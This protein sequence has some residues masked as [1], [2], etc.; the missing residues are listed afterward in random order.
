MKY[1]LLELKAKSKSFT[2]KHREKRV[3]NVTYK[4]ICYAPKYFLFVIFVLFFAPLRS[5][6][7]ENL[8]VTLSGND[9]SVD[10]IFIIMKQQHNITFSYNNNLLVNKKIHFGKTKLTVVEIV[11]IISAEADVNYKIQVNKVILYPKKK[12]FGITGFIQDSATG[13]KLPGAYIRVKATDYGVEADRDGHYLLKLESGDYVLV[14]SFVG[15]E[16]I[17][18]AITLISE[19]ELSLSLGAATSNIDEVKVTRQRNFWRNLEKG[20][21]M[22]TLDSKKIGTL[23]T[24]NASDILQASIPGVWSTQASGAPGDHQK[25]KIRGINS[26]FGCTDP[27]YIIDGVAVP[28]VNLHSLGIADLNIYD[29]EN[30][31][32]FKDASSNAIYGFQGGNGVIIID[33]K[34]GGEKHISFS[35]KIGIQRIPKR[36]GLMNTKDFLTAM[37]SAVKNNINVNR[38]Y[39]PAYSN[40]LCSTNWQDAVFQDGVLHEYQL[41]GSG[42]IGKNNIYISGNY[43][44]HDGIIDYSS[45][46]RYTASANFGRNF[47]KKLSTELNVRSS[48]QKNTNN[49]DTYNGNNLLIEGINKSPCLKCTP[50]SFYFWPQDPHYMGVRLPINR[51]NFNYQLISSYPES[52]ISTDSIIK[53]N[54]NTLNVLSNAIDLRAKYSF[55]DNLFLNA[56]SSVTLRNNLYQSDIKVDKINSPNFMRSNEHY[57]LFNQQINLNYQKGINNHE[58]LVTSGYRNYADNA[59][60]NLDSIQN[61]NN[62]DNIYLKNSLAI[63]GN[64][65]SVIRQIQSFSALLNYNYSKKYF[66]SL[67]ANYETLTVDKTMDYYALY[68]SIAASWDMSR[69]FLLNR[70]KW[71]D[72][73]SIFANW[74]RVGNMP[75]NALATDFYTNY[76]YNY[77]DTIINGRAVSQFANHY[78]KPEI[79][80]E[81]NLGAKIGLLNKRIRFTADYYFKTSEN[82]IIIRDIPIF[83]GDGRMMLNVGKIV[84]QGKEFSLDIDAVSTANF[85]WS[86][87]F[88]I[89]TNRLQ[90][91]KIGTETQLEFYNSD[92][93]IPQFEVKENEELGVIK[94]YKYLG[95]FI[96]ADKK[97]NDIR[98]TN[99]GGGKYLNSDTAIKSLTAND[100]MVI[101][102]TLPDFTWHWLN[103][104][105]YKNLS[106]EFLWYGVQGV[107]KFNATKAATFM[108]GTNRE[109]MNFMQNKNK[110]LTN[111][112]FYQSSYFVEDA[113][114]VRLKQFTIAYKVPKKIFNL[115]DLKVSVSFENFITLTRYTGYDPEATIYTDNSFSDYAVDRG[116]YPNPKSVYLTLNLDF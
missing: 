74:G 29:I 108:A 113:S 63:N 104:F 58:F 96:A 9:I 107:D 36:Y 38:R 20:R 61:R 6:E 44:T 86:T 73:L 102:K 57:I 35:T 50:D 68:P 67:V 46:K 23:N 13:E 19:T 33:T 71:L 83:Y 82:L 55:V 106:I 94:G 70:L 52:K 90:V 111:S 103:T 89:S 98:Y 99:S 24:N 97:A 84:N 77:G 39:Y 37:D 54:S 22:N 4:F 64:H 3:R 56:A 27:L 30:I 59:Y 26:I 41:S 81:Y 45:Y 92:I 15:Y 66:V 34:H 16:P 10:S 17:E 110:T 87:S 109:I 85:L 53:S 93:L 105:S 60:W 65:G 69:E 40:S 2:F 51:T 11:R 49:L 88:A 1:S 47:T 7:I 100:M 76:R 116:A 95:V 114:F 79:I 42:N 28:I 12:K 14:F 91:K 18:K 115:A 8:P 101:G 72:E 25:V 80:N 75:I 112:A 5:Q 32:V 62:T 43:Y 31:T 21:N 48:L 78:M